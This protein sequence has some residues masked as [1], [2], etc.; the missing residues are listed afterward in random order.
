MIMLLR[1]WK[2]EMFKTGEWAYDKEN[3]RPVKIIEANDLWGYASYNVYEPVQNRS[4]ILP[5]DKV[6][7]M[8]DAEDEFDIHYFRYIIISAR[9]NNEL[10]NGILSS[11]G[12]NIIPLPHQIYALNRALSKNKVR[13]IIADEVGL[14]K[15]IEAG[16]IIKELKT[17]GL[18]RRILIICPKG[19][20]TQ[21]H[22]EMKNK[23]NE[24]FNIVLPEDFGSIKR[25]YGEGNAWSHFS[26]VICSMDSVKPMEKRNGWDKSKIDEYNKER[27]KSLISASWDMV[28]IDEA[29]R[30]AGS[31]SDVA[32]YK[33]GKGLAETSPY[34]LLLTAT[35]HQ[36]KTEPFLRL[37]RL[38]DRNAFPDSNAIV[39]EQVAPYLIRTEKR[40]AVD[41][42]GNRLFKSRITKAVNISWE[43]RHNIQRQLYEMVTDYVSEGYN[44]AVRE[45]KNYLGFLMVLMQRLVTSSTRAIKENLKKRLSILQSHEVQISKLSE[46]ELWEADPEESVEDLIGTKSL[47]IKKEIIDI[48]NILAVANQAENQY[49]DAKAEKLL[50][51]LYKLQDDEN[52]KA[53]VFTEFVAT[54]KFLKELLQEKGYK[55]VI[56]NGSM[57]ID[58]RNR[59]LEDFKD[60]AQILVSTDAGGEGLNLQFCNI[61]VNYDLPWNPMKIEQRIGRVDRIGQ[62]RDV[63]VFNF[64]LS[65]TVEFRIR[66]VLEE[67]LS[68]IFKQLGVD[69]MGDVLDSEDAEVDFTDVYIKGI[70]NPKDIGYYTDKL[71]GE[72]RD[73]T[74]RISEI[75][76]LLKDEKVI[77]KSIVKGINSLPLQALLRQ[78]YI[79]YQ[80]SKGYEANLIQDSFIDLN[81]EQV[82]KMLSEMPISV[83]VNRIP[84]LNVEG[85]N[86]ER[87]YWSLWEVNIN[88][89]SKNRRIFPLFINQ[90]NIMRLAS[91]KILWEDMLKEES[92]IYF[93]GYKDFDDSTYDIIYQK[94]GDCAF[95]LFSKMKENYLNELS[96]EQE[97]YRY[98]FKLRKE[99]A[100][101]IGLAAVRIHRI[102][103]IEKEEETWEKG[104]QRQRTIIPAL[105]PI[106][107]VFLE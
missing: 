43:L 57:D 10:A 9:I 56:L 12:D 78:M 7:N 41:A 23:F 18:I 31:S 95:N 29:H 70:T 67:K 61:V 105:K 26:Q 46:D 22:S 73:K 80:F 102:K 50:E 84:V 75:K 27:F 39:K 48:K 15:T 69:K 13:Y 52:L 87:G 6:C 47:N 89:S 51:F 45:K 40:E 30:I 81:N 38:L 107:I 92:K 79:N 94:A 66:Q 1:G 103:S 97:K 60:N 4:Y 3:K 14:G 33:L 35:P 2:I 86:N 99:A 98:A 101:R 96:K 37:I 77:D 71:E 74:K 58:E 34:L 55:T 42:E 16:L 91:S 85:V 72:I 82:K 59:V 106:C 32:R 25:I 19:L 83:K 5:E 21:W 63:Y 17:R 104:I 53:I 62:K 28:I 11:I 88:G 54:Q 65:G 44:R 49:V 8:T 20:L 64:M 90:N 24:D 100:E 68:V 93:K 76:G 36:G